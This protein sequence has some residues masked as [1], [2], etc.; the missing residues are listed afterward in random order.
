VARRTGERTV[1]PGQEAAATL[2]VAPLTEWQRLLHGLFLTA[3]GLGLAA[4]V[5]FGLTLTQG[6]RAA[7]LGIVI[8]AVPAVIVVLVAAAR[9]RRRDYQPLPPDAT[10][11][12]RAPLS[13]RGWLFTGSAIVPL[14]VVG[15]VAGGLRGLALVAGC[16]LGWPAVASLQNLLGVNKASR[17]DPGVFVQVVPWW[18]SR[19]GYY[20]R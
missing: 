10:V 1:E 3:G 9:P 19:R 13:R 6:A 15:T 5:V 4:S 16:S 2:F 14:F 17:S 8:V 11:L 12:S 18:W 20:R 7:S